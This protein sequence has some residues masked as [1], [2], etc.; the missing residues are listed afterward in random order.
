M[1]DF[2]FE[3][4]QQLKVEVVDCDDDKNIKTRLIGSAEFELGR[5]IGSNNNTL[6][7]PLMDD[8]KTNGNIIVRSEKVARDNDIITMDFIVSSVPAAGG[9][10]GLVKHFIE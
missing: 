7:L 8:K 2:V 9:C 3:R 10:C 1:V 5:L 6:I 4:V